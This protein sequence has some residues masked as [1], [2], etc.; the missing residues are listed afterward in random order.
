[1][2]FQVNTNIGALNAYNALAKTNADTYKAQLRMATGKRINTVADDTSGYNIGRSLMTK[3]DV[4]KASQSNISS[5]K[6][7]LSTAET[8]LQSIDDLATKLK[9]KL[10]DNLDPTKDHISLGNDINA[11]AKEI[12]G[13]LENTNFNGTAL[14]S[15]AAATA[16]FS[17]QTGLQG[18]G[19][20]AETLSLDFASS[21]TSA[22]SFASSTDLV[23][24]AATDA[25][26]QTNISAAGIATKV[27]D[28]ITNVK[29]A[30]GKI[31]NLNQRLDVKNDYLTSAIS[32]ATASVSRLF[33]ADMAA[34]QLNATKG[35]LLS[36][37]GTAMLSQLN[38][39]PQN[40]LQLFR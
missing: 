8:S 32:N 22:S 27:D 31:G 37:A 20:T 39:A 16:G 2:A 19:K 28:L 4:M 35:S 17:F 14:L 9:A 3:S 26:T 11:L 25:A 33:D 6:N 5:A 30:L 18:D 29:N 15:S 10:A 7:L 1:M 38:S 36:Q 12:G 13:M 21:I 24:V 40:V 23:T 34:E